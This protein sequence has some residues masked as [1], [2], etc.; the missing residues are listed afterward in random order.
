M[1]RGY[2]VRVIANL[3]GVCPLCH[4]VAWIN[5]DADP[6]LQELVSGGV[7]RYE[8]PNRAALHFMCTRGDRD[9]FTVTLNLD[10]HGKSLSSA[11][12]ELDLPDLSEVTRDSAWEP[13]ILYMLEAVRQTA[14]S[15]AAKIA[16]I[17][18]VQ[19]EIHNQARVTSNGGRNADFLA[20]LF[21]QPLQSDT[22]CHV[23]VPSFATHG[24]VMAQRPG[25]SGHPY[26]SQVRA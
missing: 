6:E 24:H 9:R 11:L 22:D 4:E 8:L 2:A 13:W 16:A 26:R 3:T 23:S 20:V 12:L 17:R 21:E 15:T 10:A 19:E 7:T 5:S 18:T 1:R 14:D 25:Q